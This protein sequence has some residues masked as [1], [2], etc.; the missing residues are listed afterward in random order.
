MIIIGDDV[1]IVPESILHGTTS[2]ASR[3]IESE[4]LI[5][6]YRRLEKIHLLNPLPFSSRG[7]FKD[8]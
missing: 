8:S 4:T 1:T 6:Y 3:I 7:V 2:G 5:C